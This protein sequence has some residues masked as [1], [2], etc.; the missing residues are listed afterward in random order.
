MNKLLII[1]GNSLLNRAFYAL[2]LLSNSEGIYT[3]AVF[4]FCN[5]LVKMIQEQRPTHI[6]VAMDYERKT[7]RNELYADYKGTRHETPQELV[8]Q[9]AVLEEILSAMKIKTIKIQGIEADDIIGTMAKNFGV[10]TIIL[11]GDRDSLQLIDKNVEV[12][13]TKKG[14]SEIQVM[15][16]R[17]LMDDKGIT[18]SQVI[19]LKSLMGDASDNIPGVKGIGEVGALKL[20]KEYSTLDNVYAHLDDLS[21]ALKAKL[22]VDKEM[23]YLSYK[24]ATIKTDCDIDC[25]LKDCTY[26]FP[27]YNDVKLLFTKYQFAL[28]LKRD[29]IFDAMSL[30]HQTDSEVKEVSGVQ[31]DELIKRLTSV[32]RLAVYVDTNLHIAY[33]DKVDYKINLQDN[34]FSVTSAQ[35]QALNEVFSIASEVIVYGKKSL[36]RFMEKLGVKIGDV[37]DAELANYLIDATDKSLDINQFCVKMKEDLPVVAI[38]NS[39]EK[40]LNELKQEN[41][42]DLFS[43][44]ETPLTDVLYDMENDGI[45]IDIEQLKESEIKYDSEL[46]ELTSNI[47][48][49]AGEEFNIN[50]PK[51]VGEILFDKLKLYT[52]KKHST[53]IEHLE[54]LKDS[55]PIVPLIIRYRKILKMKN[56]Y[57]DS[58]LKF[59]NNGYIHTTFNQM[60]TVTGRLSST[61]PNMQ[62]IPAR[63]DEAKLI[64]NMF[65]SRFENGY[66]I[67]ADYSQIELRLMACFSGDETM[68]RSFLAGEDIHTATASKIH[69][70]PLSE[71]TKQQRREAKAVNFGIIYG[72]GAFGLSKGINS[73]FGSAQKFITSY[74]ETYPKVKEYIE[75]CKSNAIANNYTVRTLFN[76]QR[77]VM[78]LASSNKQLKQ[79]GERIAINTPL[80]GSASD[81]IKKAMIDLTNRIKQENLKSKLILQIHDELIV[82]SPADEVEKVAEI[83]KDCM[84]NAVNLIIPLTVDIS[85]GKTLLK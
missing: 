11:T 24:L 76:R 81:I 22:T 8:M 32:K 61:D 49:V 12:W 21:P 41:L 4:G 29:G 6:A 30:T 23:A 15:D 84:T 5:M 66:L 36:K 46:K 17:A 64:R 37:F 19:D 52:N 57:I 50:S 13:L 54:Q 78:E 74:F 45:K 67:S 31:I 28:L 79:F 43:K 51:Q 82:D 25:A 33:D 62:N 75:A 40:L 77:K 44:I 71:V 65:V 59:Q 68:T 7:F 20:I 69:H 38:F 85:V 80:Q 9:F 14:I 10:K 42:Y 26:K 35:L 53:S 60:S 34:L 16:E 70:I 48:E 39:Y 3:N 58:Y 73:D 2:P 1:D 56:T 55:H 83:M 72:Q 27:F 18:P 47:Y 63:D